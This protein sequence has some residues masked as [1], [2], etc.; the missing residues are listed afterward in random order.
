MGFLVNDS[1]IA[2]EH[3]GSGDHLK[4]IEHA[5]AIAEAIHKDARDVELQ[6]TCA[7]PDQVAGDPGKLCADHANVLRALRGLDAEEFFG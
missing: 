6:S 1:E 5:L 7:E 3:A 4:N 2:G